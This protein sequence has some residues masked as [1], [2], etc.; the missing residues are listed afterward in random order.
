MEQLGRNTGVA[1]Q[2]QDD[3]LDVFGDEGKFGK[4]RGGD[5]I[6]EKKTYLLIRAREKAD[7]EQLERL[8]DALKEKDEGEKV[9]RVVEL[10]REL[11]VEEE[12]K[13]L[14]RTYFDE[15]RKALERASVDEERKNSVRDLLELLHEREA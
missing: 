9:R 15:A 13:E 4:Q 5:I 14:S 8:E 1:F 11:G 2:L 10:Y 12:S 3:L 6:A 7:G